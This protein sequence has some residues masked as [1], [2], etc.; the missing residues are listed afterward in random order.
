M[1]QQSPLGNVRKDCAIRASTELQARVSLDFSS[2]SGALQD[3]I[4]RSPWYAMTDQPISS[5]AASK[6]HNRRIHVQHDPKPPYQPVFAPSVPFIHTSQDASLST[7]KEHFRRLYDV[8]HLCVAR[9]DLVR[10]RR[11]YALLVRCREFDW[12]TNW[13][14][15]IDMVQL[16]EERDNP[17]SQAVAGMS[18][19]SSLLADDDLERRR[20]DLQVRYLRECHAVHSRKAKS[21][22]SL[23]EVR[24]R[25]RRL[26][27][28][29]YEKHCTGAYF[30][31]RML[32]QNINETSRSL[33]RSS[34]S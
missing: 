25:A 16:P 29:L 11:A 30:A 5:D 7:Q 19:S 18:S 15:G 13:R 2:T 24:A 1:S 10:A 32:F 12:A 14:S 17:A 6:N 28:L 20:V 9:G 3:L 34:S 22:R 8:W 33:L 23:R 4:C 31:C 27:L 21:G 26:R